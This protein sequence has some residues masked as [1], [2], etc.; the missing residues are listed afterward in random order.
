[1]PAVL[2]NDTDAPG[3]FPPHSVAIIGMSGRFPGAEGLEE[4]W[5]LMAAG[6]STVEPAPV[7]RIGLSIL[8]EEHP[9]RAWWGNFLRNP[10]EFDHKFFNMTSREA[11]AWDPQQRILLEVTYDALYHAG[12]FGAARASDARD[13]GCYIGA[14]MNNYYDNVSCHK[15][16]AYATVGT[17]RCYTSG[18]ISHFFRWTGPAITMDT[19]CS[20][21]LV[22][23]HAACKAILAGEC[24]RAIAGGT[25]V[26]TSPYDYRNLAAAGFLSP[27]GQCKPFDAEGDGYC[28][29]EG[30]GV[31]VLKSLATALQENDRILGVIVGSAVSQSSN[32]G[33]ITVPNS[34]AQI[35]LQQK[36][37]DLAG[38]SPGDV[39]Y[40]EAHGTGTRIGDP[41]EV[42]AIRGAY[43]KP[44][45]SSPLYMSSIKGNIGHTE[46]TAGVA[47]LIKVLLMMNRGMIPPQGSHKSL[48]PAIPALE[49]DNIVIPLELT[50]WI[51]PGRVACVA[52]YGAG[53]SNATML[54]RE[55]P[56]HLSG[57]T[58]KRPT[59]ESAKAQ[60]PLFLAAATDASLSSHC[61]R[62]LHWLKALRSKGSVALQLPDVLFN[63]A[64]RADHTLSHMLS[65]TIVNLDHLEFKLNEAS[66]GSVTRPLYSPRK[67]VIF[68]LGGQVKNYVG[69]SREIYEHAR[70]FRDNLDACNDASRALGY[71]G[72]YPGVFQCTPVS[73]LVTL[74][75]ALF[76]AQYAS[77]KAWIDSGLK[78]DAVIGHSFGQL[79]ALCVCGVL[80]LS[81]ALK[82][83]GG[84]AS[85][86]QKYWGTEP[87]SMLSMRASRQEVDQLLNTLKAKI[88]YA[89]IACYNGTRDHVVVGSTKSVEALEDHIDSHPDL[90]HSIR[91]K[92]L[93]VTHGFHS[94]F[95]E[96]ILPELSELAGGLSW[97]QP[98]IHLETCDEHYSCTAFDYRLAAH[99]M[100]RPVFFQQAVERLARNY[101]ASCWLSAGH[102]PLVTRLAQKALSP[103]SSH[104]GHAF[105]YPELTT[106]NARNS[107][108]QAT[109]QVWKEGQSVQYW[110]FHRRQRYDYQDLTLPP[111]SFER[112]RHWLPFDRRLT[113]EIPDAS[114]TAECSEENGF[115]SSIGQDGLGGAI[116]DISPNSL[117]FQMLCGG[118]IMAGEALA[119]ASLFFEVAARAALTLQGDAQAVP[120]IPSVDDLR[121]VAPIGTN[122]NTVIQLR[123]ERIKGSQSSWSFSVKTLERPR[124]GQPSSAPQ[125]RL[126]GVIS[127]RRRIDQQTEQ[128]CESF[129]RSSIYRRYRLIT[130]SPVAEKMQ[131]GH[132]YRAFGPVVRYDELF[133]QVK[134]IACVGTEAAGVVA[135]TAQSR[136]DTVAHFTDA[137][138]IDGFMQAAGFLVNYFN[139][140]DLSNSLFVCQNVKRIE[141]TGVIPQQGHDYSFYTKMNL[142]SLDAASADVYVFDVNHGAVFAAQGF[143]FARVRRTSLARTLGT[144]NK[145]IAENHSRDIAEVRAS[146]GT[147]TI[148]AVTQAERSHV[149]SSTWRAKVLEILSDVSGVPIQQMM[150]H[151][152]L[153]DLGIDSLAVTEVLSD[154]RASLHLTIPLS[155]FVMFPD[156]GTLIE[157]VES[158][159]RVQDNKD[160]SGS[161][162]SYD[163]KS[164]KM[165]TSQKE[166]EKQVRCDMDAS[167]CSRTCASAQMQSPTMIAPRV[168]F[169]EVR[170]T[171]DSLIAGLSYGSEV[172]PDHVRLLQAYTLEALKKLGCDV[173]GTKPGNAI[174]DVDG[175]LTRHQPLVRQL[176]RMLEE[177]RIIVAFEG[178]FVR[179]EDIIDEVSGKEVY[180]ALRTRWPEHANILELVHAV[181]PCLA[182]CL[183]G[184]QDILEIIFGNKTSKEVL[185]DFYEN[186]PLFRVS[187]TILTD[188]LCRSFAKSSGAGRFRILEVGA[189]MGGTTRPLLETLVANNIPF[190]YHFTD[191]SPSLVEAA[192]SSFGDVDGITF[193]TLDIEHDPP[194][195]L[196]GSFQVVI[197]ANSVHATRDLHQSLTNLRRMLR[198]DG[199]LTLI[200]ITRNVFTFDL[201]FG[202][203][204]G[205]WRSTDGRSHA[206]ID[207]RHWEKKLT[208]VGFH[209]V[210]WTDGQCP[211]SKTVR[212]IAAFPRSNSGETTHTE[213][214]QSRIEEVVYKK[215]DTLEILAD[216]YCPLVTESGKLSPIG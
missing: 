64:D 54:V 150:D 91:K 163:A 94:A 9:Q 97:N 40:I 34:S 149:K 95:T 31:V 85:L 176:L 138:M 208:E 143:R 214:V 36:V 96:T 74:H 82:L 1:M 215:S 213:A 147:E 169:E 177:R 198:K 145:S 103:H 108:M 76:A 195:E 166:E 53:G 39:S 192:R 144:M 72:I 70:V 146:Q 209:D 165:S 19:A 99:H 148:R 71:R 8:L 73:S 11:Q 45:R 14:V 90:R 62:L 172:Y 189:G 27:S 122:K 48:N 158:C 100:R 182:E 26:I 132:I 162:T 170:M 136:S 44:Q 28:R 3:E 115:I 130:D 50:P 86:I 175:V 156:I 25:N 15:P 32:G 55:M 201:I 93:A 109:T 10:E 123:L 4:L 190:D 154:M 187:T 22:A 66:S 41:I 38:M 68:V 128:S 126:S 111:Y 167:N 134:S 202:L 210:M 35:S 141:V 119:P 168:S 131:G 200:E 37:M 47:G 171:Y 13:Y 18:A 121:M 63:I 129:Q 23:I 216:V 98:T 89:E 161:N 183:T 139:N 106:A 65:T 61:T 180:Q 24:T 204:A 157:Y 17:S 196:Q 152:T 142:D 57:T 155:T 77:A 2:P 80:S 185:Q 92:R 124:A 105:I 20:S 116:F 101:S 43:C 78:V 107:L 153:E 88:D 164:T 125:E 102:D 151:R 29:A 160:E 104:G 21:S 51:G 87:G 199:V 178:L 5:D 83:V 206:L 184:E 133:R 114:N 179:T 52:S 56:C 118:H 197:A 188:F 6:K 58:P 117:R 211:D 30:V 49:P 12:Y 81:D 212:V 207:E 193:D 79:T 42:A 203:F 113:G 194:V 75:V 46:A 137:I 127:L 59:D 181:G 140:C 159:L 110:P 16:T 60:L 191:V 112:S 33:Q 84:R 67:P 120:W 205:W 135:A 7:E 174:P 173:A 69:L 186:W